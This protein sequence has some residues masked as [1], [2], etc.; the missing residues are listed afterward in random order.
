MKL[1]IS[2]RSSQAW[3]TNNVG[4][5]PP[6]FRRVLH[7]RKHSADVHPHA[8][9]GHPPDPN[10]AFG[11]NFL[12]IVPKGQ[13]KNRLAAVSAETENRVRR[14]HRTRFV[15]YRLRKSACPSGSAILPNPI[16]KSVCRS[17]LTKVSNPISRPPF[18]R[19]GQNALRSP[20]SALIAV[21]PGA[22]APRPGPPAPPAWSA[23]PIP[24]VR[25]P[26]R[27]RTRPATR[28]R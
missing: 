6:T 25:L 9:R 13:P 15:R 22:S 19:L 10:A 26:R 5:E 8:C 11:R 28:K 18:P 14:I 7:R 24:P 3:P 27:G 16:R 20:A 4:G 12:A 21:H 17:G 23:R 2:G 1:F